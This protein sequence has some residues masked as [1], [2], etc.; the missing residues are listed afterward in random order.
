LEGFSVT[1]R[2]ARPKKRRADKKFRAEGDRGRPMGGAK[3]EVREETPRKGM[4]QKTVKG[5]G[6]RKKNQREAPWKEIA[7]KGGSQEGFVGLLGK[8]VESGKG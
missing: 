3:R 8:R 2:T 7:K 4:K 5:L 6:G 1:I